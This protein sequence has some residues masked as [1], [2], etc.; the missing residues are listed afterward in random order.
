MTNPNSHPKPITQPLSAAFYVAISAVGL[1]VTAV[2]GWYLL[3]N[4]NLLSSGNTA[5]RAYY[6]LL[7]VLGLAAAAFL[8]G[9]MRSTARLTG[10]ELGAAYEFGGPVVV[11]ILVV[12]GGFYLIKP[13][14]DFGL[15]IRLRASE[16]ITDATETWARVDLGARRDERLFSRDGEVQFSGLPAR[17][18]DSELPIE[19][20][21]K[22]FKLKE[23][24]SAYKIS[25]NGVLYLDVLRISPGENKVEVGSRIV[26]SHFIGEP[27]TA[28]GLRVI[29]ETTKPTDFSDLAL[30]LKS[31]SGASHS[32]ILSMVSPSQKSNEST[33]PPPKWRVYPGETLDVY[34][35]WARIPW[36]MLGTALGQRIKQL[37]EYQEA[38][39]WPCYNEVKLSSAATAIVQKSLQSAFI[40]EAGKW[41]F[42]FSGSLDGKRVDVPFVVDLSESDI[43]GMKA[44][45]DFYG[46]CQGINPA[47][48]FVSSGAAQTLVDKPRRDFTAPAVVAK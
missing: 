12:V 13:P 33:P 36:Q 26:I 27:I 23:P 24:K 14:D 19:L 48:M 4:P 9:A 1:L 35:W 30:D 45:S 34:L 3:T 43:A 40:W 31:P 5:A 38:N 47:S 6:V 2:I 32:L 8:F 22:A 20:I 11:A 25:S 37:P 10:T 17:Y 16:P 7:L 18:L 21:S 39:R 44:V 46:E 15:T 29:N 42:D 41:S 28:F